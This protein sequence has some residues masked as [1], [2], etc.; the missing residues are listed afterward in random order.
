MKLVS[1]KINTPKILLGLYIF[2]LAFFDKAIVCG[3]DSPYIYV[4]LLIF[5]SLILFRKH[6]LI[7]KQAFMWLLFLIVLLMSSITSFSQE[8]ILTNSLRYIVM[9]FIS[10]S[11]YNL[12]LFYDDNVNDAL[13]FYIMLALFLSILGIL[14]VIEFNFLHSFRLYFPPNNLTFVRSGGPGAVTKSG[15]I[16]FRAT[17]TFA[18]PSW[19]A[20]YLFPALVLMIIRYFQRNSFHNLCTVCIIFIGFISAFSFTGIILLSAFILLYIGWKFLY[21]MFFLRLPNRRFILSVIFAS[22]MVAILVVIVIEYIPTAKNY[23]VYCFQEVISGTDAS[24]SM[25]KDSIRQ[26]ID[27]FKLHPIL[28]V[29]IGSYQFA[30]SQLYGKPADV[31]IDSGYFLILAELGI[32]GIIAFIGVIWQSIFPTMRMKYDPKLQEQL[33]WLIVSH[34]LLFISYNWWYHPLFWFHLTIPIACKHFNLYK[35]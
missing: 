16:I 28:G 5:V 14:Q 25:R 9:V 31:S 30:A 18:E 12:M 1:N 21:S 26:A 33:M 24:T 17:G 34:I 4:G 20:Y 32:I 19:M 23:L 29:G 7:P 8:K 3:Y 35:G 10:I 2:S 27:L 11:L 15:Y 22:V 13:H 6:I